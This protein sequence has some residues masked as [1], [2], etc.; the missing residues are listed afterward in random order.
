MIRGMFLAGGE[1]REALAS[2]VQ[3]D[4]L[5]IQVMGVRQTGSRVIILCH[6]TIFRG[7]SGQESQPSERIL[8][9]LA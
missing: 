1:R 9:G 5:R 2:N 7:R 6:I 8:A 3:H 4:T